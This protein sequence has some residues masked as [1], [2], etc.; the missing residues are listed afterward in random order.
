MNSTLTSTVEKQVIFELN[1]FLTLKW[2]NNLI[3]AV[4]YFL[5]LHPIYLCRLLRSFWKVTLKA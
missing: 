4:I 2:F 3:L 5:L 1:N